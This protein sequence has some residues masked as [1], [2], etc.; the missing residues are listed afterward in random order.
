MHT[1][2]HTHYTNDKVGIMK[3]KNCFL[4]DTDNTMVWVTLVCENPLQLAA[5]P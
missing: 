1:H 5:Q 4:R 2:K 3:V